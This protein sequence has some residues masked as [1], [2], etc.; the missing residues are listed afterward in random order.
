MADSSPLAIIRLFELRQWHV[1]GAISSC[2]RSHS[3]PYSAR[4]ASICDTVI[5]LGGRTPPGLKCRCHA[6]DRVGPFL[7]LNARTTVIRAASASRLWL[8]RHTGLGCAMP[9]VPICKVSTVQPILPAIEPPAVYLCS[10]S[11][12]NTDTYLGFFRG[13][14]HN[15]TL[16]GNG[17][18]GKTGA[19]HCPRVL[20]TQI[21]ARPSLFI[22]YEVRV[23][24]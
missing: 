22:I 8:N 11:S 6:Q 16:S 18:S 3:T 5:S 20:L 13:L 14:I 1:D 7:A 9:D 10:Y 12:Y 23:I 24:D 19:V 4:Y 2:A 15:S 17:V 21:L